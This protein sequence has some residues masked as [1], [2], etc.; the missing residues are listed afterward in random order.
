MVAFLISELGMTR[1]SVVPFSDWME[2]VSSAIEKGNPAKN[3]AGFLEREFPKMSCGDIVLD[4]HVSRQASITMRNM[5]AVDH[6]TI[7]AYLRY[8]KEIAVFE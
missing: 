6:E 7:R 5:Q 8:W 2:A 1:D 3:L 4:T